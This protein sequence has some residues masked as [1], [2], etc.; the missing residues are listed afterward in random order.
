MALRIERPRPAGRP[1]RLALLWL[2]LLWLDAGCAGLD[3]P[4]PRR[5]IGWAGYLGG[6]DLKA[7]CDA[8]L[9][10]RARLVS[11]D[12]GRGL[13]RT[14][15]VIDDGGGALVL[16]QDIPT[17]AVA[18]NRFPLPERPEPRATRLTARDLAV[19]WYWLDRLVQPGPPGA[20]PGLPGERSWLISGCRDGQWFFT[21]GLSGEEP[22]APM[23]WRPP[24]SD[25]ARPAAPAPAPAGS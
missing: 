2:A 10:D 25:R 12:Q 3:A 22:G 18:E 4:D 9:P 7:V 13:I 11:R 19:L 1:W 5:G 23:A 21:V 14:L 24:F 8:D 15:D 17:E 20:V 16:S 6:L